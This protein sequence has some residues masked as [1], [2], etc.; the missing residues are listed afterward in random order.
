LDFADRVDG[1]VV[2]PHVIHRRPEG[3]E[4]GIEDWSQSIVGLHP[5]QVTGNAVSVVEGAVR[6]LWPMLAQARSRGDVGHRE[7]LRWSSRS[8]PERGDRLCNSE[9]AR[10]VLRLVRTAAGARRRSDAMTL[11]GPLLE[12][13]HLVVRRRAAVVGTGGRGEV[14]GGT[15]G[16]LDSPR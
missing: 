8:R 15:L 10:A 3:G 12:L 2:P 7:G 11:E 14:V 6:R 9:L 16:K 5:K 4:Q 13:L 1:Y